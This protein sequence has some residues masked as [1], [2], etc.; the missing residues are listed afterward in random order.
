MGTVLSNLSRS[1]AVNGHVVPHI[2]AAG[3]VS[4]I[5]FWLDF[6]AGKVF[7]LNWYICGQREFLGPVL[8]SVRGL[9]SQ[10]HSSSSQ[11]VD[12]SSLSM[13]HLKLESDCS[14][15]SG[16]DPVP[17]CSGCHHDILGGGQVR[18]RLIWVCHN[19]CFGTML[20]H[21]LVLAIL[22]A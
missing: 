18:V 20:R 13:A 6:A 3:S 21:G 10:S 22:V 15:S 5:V 11:W 17:R 19:Y 16:C 7:A 8:A 4:Q 12:A 1:S 14:P 9:T 2:F